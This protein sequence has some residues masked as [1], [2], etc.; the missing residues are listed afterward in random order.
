MN[1]KN[2]NNYIEFKVSCHKASN[3]EYMYSFSNRDGFAEHT[4]LIISEYNI[5]LHKKDLLILLSKLWETVSTQYSLM[6]LHK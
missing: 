3:A 4:V 1:V 5:L 6:N 2:P